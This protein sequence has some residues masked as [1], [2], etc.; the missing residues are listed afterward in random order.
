[1]KLNLARLEK[2][3]QRGSKIIA[4]CPACAEINSHAS[5]PAPVRRQ[6]PMWDMPP[7]PWTR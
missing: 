5:F 4:H 2:V 1:M 3:R 6:K 7:L